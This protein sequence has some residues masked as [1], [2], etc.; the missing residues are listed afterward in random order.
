MKKCAKC[1][2]PFESERAKRAHCSDCVARWVG[3]LEPLPGEEGDD[4]DADDDEEVAV[5]ESPSGPSGSSM[6][7]AMAVG[8]L[9]AAILFSLPD[10]SAPFSPQYSTVANFDNPKNVSPLD[11]KNHI[12]SGITLGPWG[13]IVYRH[14]WDITW[15]SYWARML[16]LTFMASIN[17]GVGFFERLRYEDAIQAQ[18]LGDDPVFILGH[19]RTGTTLMHNILSHDKQFLFCNTMQVGFPSTFISMDSLKSTLANIVDKTRPMDNMELSFDGPQEDELA[20]NQLSAGMS[21]YMPIVMMPQQQRYTPYFTYDT[22]PRPEY[23]RW[24]DSLLYFLRKVQLQSQLKRSAA[25]DAQEKGRSRFLLKSPVHTSRIKVL[26]E[27]FPK[28]QFVY[29]YRNPMAVFKSAANMADTT[30]WYTYLSKPTDAMIQHF[31]LSQY[32][33]LHREYQ[34][35]KTLIPAGRLHELRYEDLE[36][37]KLGSIRQLYAELGWEWG[38]AQDEDI[39]GYIDSLKGYTKNSKSKLSKYVDGDME[40]LL[41]SEW[42]DAF[43]ELGY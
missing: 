12:L 20:T 39:G 7:V 41:R 43:K 26:L 34:Q 31:I 33:S 11:V 35:Q 1:G 16:F 22:A 28:A 2:E 25:G 42:A 23:Q 3:G 19:P 32:T 9:A 4:D 21:P 24:R 13:E 14:F 8:V 10:P 6:F 29:V 38:A 36:Q 15:S 37:D 40:K 18:T 27:L 30:Y 17:S 5:V